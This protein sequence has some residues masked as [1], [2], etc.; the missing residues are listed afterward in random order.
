MV[1]EIK[2]DVTCFDHIAHVG[3]SDKTIINYKLYI[4]ICLAHLRHS[5]F[6][7][8]DSSSSNGFFPCNF[9]VASIEAMYW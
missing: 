9:H 5:S 2:R 7:N 8:R 6:L 1:A 4:S 3:A